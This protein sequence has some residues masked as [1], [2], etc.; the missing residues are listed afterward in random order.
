MWQQPLDGRGA[1]P[2][3]GDRLPPTMLPVG[4]GGMKV[5]GPRVQG[6]VPDTVGLGPAAWICRETSEL[7]LGLMPKK[8]APHPTPPP[9]ASICRESGE[10]GLPQCPQGAGQPKQ[11]AVG[12]QLD[13]AYHAVK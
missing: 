2:Y 12:A 10:T 11:E 6:N 5:P 1:T 9:R 4:M 8:E 7:G 3:T 13:A